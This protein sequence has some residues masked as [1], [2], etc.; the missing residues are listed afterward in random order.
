[1]FTNSKIKN[2]IKIPSLGD[3]DEDDSY[4]TFLEILRNNRVSQKLNLRFLDPDCLLGSKNDPG[5]IF[6]F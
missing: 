6:K 5:P 1:M 3:T 2:P 4:E